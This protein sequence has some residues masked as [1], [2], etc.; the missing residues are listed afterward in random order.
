MGGVARR[1]CNVIGGWDAPSPEECTKLKVF[2]LVIGIL[3]H[4]QFSPCIIYGLL[5]YACMDIYSY[6]HS[7]GVYTISVA[8]NNSS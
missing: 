6:I 1:F 4:T 5:T 2:R 8:S 3:I 7:R